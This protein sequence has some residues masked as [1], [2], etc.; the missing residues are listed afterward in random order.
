MLSCSCTDLVTEP[1]HGWGFRLPLLRAEHR[2][3]STSAGMTHRH[4]SVGV[5]GAEWGFQYL[6]EPTGAT[7]HKHLRGCHLGLIGKSSPGLL[8]KQGFTDNV[9]R[10]QT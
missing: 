5:G 1:C 6:S 2:M 10:D 3:E 7:S 4:C 8:E 9:F